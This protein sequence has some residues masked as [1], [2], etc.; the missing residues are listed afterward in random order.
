MI[1]E[2]MFD[3]D[4]S[5]I[6]TAGFSRARKYKGKY[7]TP[8]GEVTAFAKEFAAMTPLPMRLAEWRSSIA[9][10]ENNVAPEIYSEKRPDNI[11][12]GGLLMEYIDAE[13]VAYESFHSQ[14]NLHEFIHF[15]DNLHALPTNGFAINRGTANQIVYWLQQIPM[16]KNSKDN[17]KLV[18]RCHELARHALEIYSH[19]ARRDNICVCHNDL[20]KDNI[21]HGGKKGYLL[22]DWEYAGAGNPYVDLGA[23]ANMYNLKNEDILAVYAPRA[24]E[25]QEQ[26]KAQLYL[27]RLLHLIQMTL[28]STVNAIFILK[29]QKEPYKIVSLGDITPYS[30]Y[31][32]ALE[33]Y[34]TGKIKLPFEDPIK[35]IATFQHMSDLCYT[36]VTTGCSVNEYRDALTIL[37]PVGAQTNSSRMSPNEIQDYM[38]YVS[39]VEK[40]FGMLINSF[41]TYSST[42]N[43][44]FANLVRQHGLFQTSWHTNTIET[45]QVID[46]SC[47]DIWKKLTDFS[48]YPDWNPLICRAEGDIQEG[49]LL[50]VTI[51]DSQGRRSSFTPT[52]LT[53]NPNKE[54]RWL[55][56]LYFDTVF[57]GEHYFILEPLSDNKTLFIHGEKFSGVLRPAIMYMLGENFEKQFERMNQCLAD[58]VVATSVT[59]YRS[60]L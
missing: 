40:N 4:N 52:V 14:E 9:A 31:E 19:L 56:N 34:F 12:I 43:L 38:A 26:A 29:Q 30:N 51:A 32:T 22:I 13:H 5:K 1:P 33:A 6:V 57:T 46:A 18:S 8:T 7:T 45:S 44:L 2:Q 21:F 27:G 35:M 60:E 53:C 37:E 10:A 16:E 58:S 3:V 11:Q 41:A 55:G 47:E 48:Q 24:G 28:F 25:T 54:L 15:I 17:K 59:Q 20:K 50:H 23:L 49:N 39:E 36:A 42:N